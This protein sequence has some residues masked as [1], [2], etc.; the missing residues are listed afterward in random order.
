MGDTRPSA[1]APPSYSPNERESRNNQEP[2]CAARLGDAGDVFYV[3]DDHSA[4]ALH[5]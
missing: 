3:T 2:G 4:E 1:L 5:C